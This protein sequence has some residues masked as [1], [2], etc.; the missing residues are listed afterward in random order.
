MLDPGRNSP[1]DRGVAIAIEHV[2][3]TSV[4]GLAAKPVID[5][6]IVVRRDDVP[7]A[8]EILATL[9][10]V[11]VG[12]QGIADREAFKYSFNKPAHHLYV[13]PDDSAEL[14]RQILFRDYLRANPEVAQQYG[15]LKQ[16]LAK[17]YHD[18]RVA[19]TDAKTE[20]IVGVMQKALTDKERQISSYL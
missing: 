6:N 8:T 15:E 17:Q 3:S 1:G 18:D 12:N 13:T 19:Y 7:K 5:M 16:K 10:Y 11:H 2:G 9:R 4:P 20:F 14:Q